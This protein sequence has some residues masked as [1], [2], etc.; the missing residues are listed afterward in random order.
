MQHDILKVDCWPFDPKL[1]SGG[2]GLQQNFVI[3]FNLI[4]TMTMFWKSWFLT[5]WPHS[6]RSWGLG[7]RAN[8]CYHVAAFLIPFD[9][10]SN[11]TIFWKWNFDFFTQPRVRGLGVCSTILW[12]LGIWYATW[13]CSE[14]VDF[15]PI[16]PILRVE[17]MQLKHLLPCCCIRYS[18]KFDVH[19]DIALKKL[20]L[21]F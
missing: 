8:I 5:Y 3:P 9:L 16:D 6:L 21:T 13:Q 11:M 14:K 15:W 18:L 4:C 19:H 12:L 17:G 10:I 20:N 1:G 2:G 7:L